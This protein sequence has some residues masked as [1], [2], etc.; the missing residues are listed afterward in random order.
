MSKAVLE[1][2]QQASRSL[3][4]TAESVKT[5]AAMTGDYNPLPFDLQFAEQTPFGRRVRERGLPSG[6]LHA[7]VAM[8][9]PGPGTVCLSQNWKFTAPVFIGDPIAATAT[10]RSLHAAR[11]VTQIGVRV[12]RQDGQAVLE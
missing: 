10:S 2:G 3:T 4:L 8:D 11:P 7:L 5:F 6:P 9:V 12:V 1:V